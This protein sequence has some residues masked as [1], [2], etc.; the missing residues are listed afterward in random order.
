MVN[1]FERVGVALSRKT[2]R[3]NFK[4]LHPPFDKKGPLMAP[5][6]R[7]DRLKLFRV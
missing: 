6:S 4:R 5:A 2:K 3:A 7:A 1:Q